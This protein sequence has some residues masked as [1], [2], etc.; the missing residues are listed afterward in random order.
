MFNVFAP[1]TAVFAEELSPPEATVT[2][3]SLLDS[4]KQVVSEGN[5][6]KIG[7]T[8]SLELKLDIQALAGLKLKSGDCYQVNL[9]ENTE[10]GTWQAEQ[11][12]PKEL[13]NQADETV[14]SFIIENQKILMTLNEA[15]ADLE[16]LEVTLET[17]SV[18][19]TDVTAS[20]SQEV[21]VGDVLQTLAFVKAEEPNP[22]VE[23]SEESEEQDLEV[24]PKAPTTQPN[25]SRQTRALTGTQTVATLAEFDS[26]FADTTVDKIVLTANIELDA[27][28][29]LA[30]SS[31]L[32][33]TS[34]SN[35]PHQLTI[36]PSA[37]HFKLLAG[38]NLT[39]ENLVIEGQNKPGGVRVDS[40]TTG[41]SF[42]TIKD[43]TFKN[44][45]STQGNTGVNFGGAI[46]AY[47]GAVSYA[48]LLITGNSA[49][50]NNQA[51]YGGA[52]AV[53]QSWITVEGETRFSG[54]TVVGDGW[55]GSTLFLQG[56]VSEIKDNVTFTGNGTTGK[57]GGA[58]MLYGGGDASISGNVL[59]HLVLRP[60]SM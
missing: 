52:I 29:E 51:Y 26:A 17:D 33:I 58:V 6:I 27:T 9:P 41:R 47:D 5:P 25:K 39:L 32:T 23:T 38:A 12:V 10:N 3:W 15:V 46:D 54:N 57:E 28:K 43:T 18:L 13:K 35:G 48:T 42:L 4:D 16:R 56:A 22:L 30:T 59:F 40:N 36:A 44:C 19:T 8:Y 11:L 55:G 1:L 21:Q 14:G 24:L 34:D 53:K 37:R 45:K 60:N 49:F 50:L 7:G 2:A 20:L 31:T